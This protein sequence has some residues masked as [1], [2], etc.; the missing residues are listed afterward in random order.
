MP[1]TWTAIRQWNIRVVGMPFYTRTYIYYL[2]KKL[3][4][5]MVSLGMGHSLWPLWSFSSIQ[6][7][8]SAYIFSYKFNVAPI[9]PTQ[10]KWLIKTNETPSMHIHVK[11]INSPKFKSPT[12][13]NPMRF[14]CI[15]FFSFLCTCTLS[16][17]RALVCVYIYIII[18]MWYFFI[19]VLPRRPIIIILMDSDVK[20]GVVGSVRVFKLKTHTK[21]YY[22]HSEVIID[23]WTLIIYKRTKYICVYTVVP[24]CEIRSTKIN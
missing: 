24:G 1:Y 16:H 5:T 19:R 3:I 7:C 21:M 6:K 11:C 10:N 17:A 8:S 2:K 14:N 22:F 13:I 15:D 9:R 18:L 20:D 23:R 12:D 4:P